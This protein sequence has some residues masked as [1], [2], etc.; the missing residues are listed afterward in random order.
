MPEKSYYDI[1]G[2]K[3]S[4]TPAEIKKAYRKLARTHH[5]D[6]GGDEET[7]KRINE[8]YEVLSD[9][10]KKKNYD[11]YGRYMGEIPT[12]AGS[13]AYGQSP[14]GGYRP[15][16]YRYSESSPNGW[17]EIFDSIRGGEGMFGSSWEMPK[18]SKKGQE[19]KA[20]LG[21]TFDEAFNGVSKKVTIRIP[22]TGEKQ[23]LTVKVPQGAVDGG[24]L[25]YHGK[26]EY[27]TGKGERGDLVIVTRIKDDELFKRDGADVIL[28]LPVTIAEAALGAS[29]VVPAPDGSCVKIRVPAGTQEGKILRVKDKGAKKIKG[30]GYGSLKVK[31]HVVVP[32]NLN[33]KQKKTLEMFEKA[34]SGESVRSVIDSKTAHINQERQVV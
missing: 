13:S 9:P 19:I 14:F 26:G 8:A 6:A 24:K 20:E 23:T 18:R 17:A 10:E 3:R 34:G 21:L 30:E 7:F 32:T 25:R 1:L 33:E 15:T 29:I 2:V 11:R 12:G 27:G 31:V 4:A 5:P 22:S 16:E 28:D